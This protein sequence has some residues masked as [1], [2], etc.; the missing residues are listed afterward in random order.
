MAHERWTKMARLRLNHPIA[1]LLF[2]GLA[3]FFLGLIAVTG[4]RLDRDA[5][6]VRA[7]GIPVTFQLAAPTAPRAAYPQRCDAQAP[8][9]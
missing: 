8:W 3:F 2:S 5:T 4:P 6:V 7:V 9:L 1:A